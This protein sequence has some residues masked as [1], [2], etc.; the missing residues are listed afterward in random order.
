MN[1]LQF[2]ILNGY[3]LVN[4]ITNKSIGI[5]YSTQSRD[6]IRSILQGMSDYKFSKIVSPRQTHTNNVVVIREENLDDELYDVD[7]VITKLKGVALTIA[8]ADCQSI[9]FYDKKRGVIGNIHSGWK[10]TLQKILRKGINLMIDE[11]DSNPEDI[12]VCIGPSILDCCFEVDEDVVNNFKSN[13]SDIDSYIKLGEV[14]DGKQKYYI[15]TVGINIDE[16]LSLG[17]LKENIVASDICTK[18]CSDIYHSYRAHGKD[19]GRNV[20]LIAMK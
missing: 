15:D 19:S 13:F 6:E 10:G 14:K 16:L 7:G 4:F 11:F 2:D 20:T 3:D 12:L 18:C 17:I 9:M 5:N 8:T 1:N